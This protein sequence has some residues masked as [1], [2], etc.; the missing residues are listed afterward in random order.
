[1]VQHTPYKKYV[2]EGS[3]SHSLH[4]AAE[5]SL[6][7]SRQVRG[8]LD[9]LVGTLVLVLRVSKSFT[10][11]CGRSILNVSRQVRG[12]QRMRR[13]VGLVSRYPCFG[14]EGQ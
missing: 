2:P 6:N 7:V 4:F 9:W 13:D 10:P 8:M 12:M 11:F 1:M 3:V 14:F 5:A